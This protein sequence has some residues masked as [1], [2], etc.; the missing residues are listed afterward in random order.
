MSYRTYAQSNAVRDRVRGHRT[1]PTTGCK[2]PR[3]DGQ[4][5]C[6]DCWTKVP[7]DIQ[8]TIWRELAESQKRRSFTHAYI[9]ARRHAIMFAAGEVRS[10]VKD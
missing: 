4:V 2:M 10:H 1:C 8:R 6:R 3:A 5:L 7:V 9:Q